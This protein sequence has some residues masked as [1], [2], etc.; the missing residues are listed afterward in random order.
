MTA[1]L[2]SVDDVAQVIREHRYRYANEDQLQRGIYQALRAARLPVI[3]EAWIAPGSRID[4]LAGRVGIEVKV[5]GSARDVL[6]Q[7]DRY[8]QSDVID[9]LVLVTSRV[10]HAALSDSHG[11]KPV[12]LVQ[13][14]GAGL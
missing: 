6:A 7:I 2:T 12:R 9:G 14:A 1:T 10:R 13:L 8:L 3:R 5:G 4:L 11:H